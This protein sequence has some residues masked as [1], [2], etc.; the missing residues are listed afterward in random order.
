LDFIPDKTR[1]RR[2]TKSDT[3]AHIELLARTLF[4]ARGEEQV[5][6]SK[7]RFLYGLFKAAENGNSEW[8]TQSTALAEFS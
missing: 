7:S 5:L 1:R 2:Q 3:I 4:P 6:Y 8:G